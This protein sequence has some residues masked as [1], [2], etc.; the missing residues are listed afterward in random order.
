MILLL[1]ITLCLCVYVCVHLRMHKTSD[2]DSAGL[3]KEIMTKFIGSPNWAECTHIEDSECCS[4]GPNFRDPH[5]TYSRIYIRSIAGG[6]IL[7]LFMW[8]SLTVI[9]QRHKVH[10]LP[11]CVVNLL[12]IGMVYLYTYYNNLILQFPFIP[13]FIFFI[14]NV[15]YFLPCANREHRASK[16][17]RSKRKKLVLFSR[18]FRFTQIYIQS[19]SQYADAAVTLPLHC[20]IYRV[21]SA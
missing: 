8:E 11:S 16:A 20:I 1:L 6:A 14:A 4:T 21:F 9:Y 19:K 7:T 10:H 13:L 17:G 12:H 2:V 3:P 18:I 5:K 15:V